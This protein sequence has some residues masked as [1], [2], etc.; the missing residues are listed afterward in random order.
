MDF[1]G[2]SGIGKYLLTAFTFIAALLTIYEIISRNTVT[3]PFIILLAIIGMV[4]T[5]V[6]QIN[7]NNKECT[8]KINN[9]KEE[10]KNKIIAISSVVHNCLCYLCR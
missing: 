2:Q 4:G 8:Q 1:K 6:Y 5:S 3:T 10:W 9:I 7:K